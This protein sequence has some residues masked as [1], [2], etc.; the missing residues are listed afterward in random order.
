VPTVSTRLNRV[1]GSAGFP[2]E[3]S[4]AS[5]VVRAVGYVNGVPGFAQTFVVVDSE[6]LRAFFGMVSGAAQDGS[7]PLRAVE[8]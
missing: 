2:E 3:I 7:E 5:W 4:T 1:R 8:S 6:G